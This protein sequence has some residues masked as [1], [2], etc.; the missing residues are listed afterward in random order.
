MQKIAEII[1]DATGE[2]EG[3]V[4]RLDVGVRALVFLMERLEGDELVK[5]FY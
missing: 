5:D 4:Y 3:E 1:S 2:N